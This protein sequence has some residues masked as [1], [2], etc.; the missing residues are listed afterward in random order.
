MFARSMFVTSQPG[1]TNFDANSAFQGGR[2]NADAVARTGG[3]RVTAGM[4]PNPSD[5]EGT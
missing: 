2:S 3:D 5:E 4:D 1:N